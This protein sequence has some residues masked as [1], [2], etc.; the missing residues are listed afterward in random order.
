MKYTM[1]MVK[2]EWAIINPRTGKE[3]DRDGKIALD[4]VRSGPM[5][6]VSRVSKDIEIALME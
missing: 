1:L 2:A 6:K 5:R 4:A 3:L